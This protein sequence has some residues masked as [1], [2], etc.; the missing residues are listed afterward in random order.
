MFFMLD[1]VIDSISPPKINEIFN[2]NI[3]DTVTNFLFF[4]FTFFK[5]LVSALTNFYNVLI[6]INS[7]VVDLGNSAQSGITGGLPI[8]ES[9][10]VYRYLIGDPIFYLTYILVLVGCLFTIYK[11]VLLLIKCFKDMKASMASTGKTSAGI[12]S[13]LSKFFT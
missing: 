2:G 9:V 10:G 6:E 3:L 1:I 13:F 4:I 8:L 7:Y 12:L 11:L 5:N